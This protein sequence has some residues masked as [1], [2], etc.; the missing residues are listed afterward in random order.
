MLNLLVFAAYTLLN[1][2]AFFSFEITELMPPAGS[3][4][5]DLSALQHWLPWAGSP[6]LPVLVTFVVQELLFLAI[7][8]L[9]WWCWMLLCI[10]RPKLTGSILSFILYP[11]SSGTFREVR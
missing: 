9:L 6:E 3:K 8:L 5:Q 7:H 1:I 11:S 2:F 10:F 4:G